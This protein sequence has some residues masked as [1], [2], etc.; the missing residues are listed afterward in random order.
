MN[1][2][3]ALQITFNCSTAAKSLLKGH[4]SEGEHAALVAV[5]KNEFA[6]EFFPMIFLAIVFL[7]L[8]D[9]ACYLK[10]L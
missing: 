5:Q 8:A 9:F 4:G 2:F 3:G 6:T 1:G 10:F 7:F